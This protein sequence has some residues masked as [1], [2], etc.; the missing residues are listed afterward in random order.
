M[1]SCSSRRKEFL[2]LS[3]LLGE[4]PE[5]RTAICSRKQDKLSIGA[6]VYAIPETLRGTNRQTDKQTNR[7]TD[8]QTNLSDK[9]I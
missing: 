9:Y 8:K 4:N 1:S 6:K 7:Q 2:E 5:T 3:E